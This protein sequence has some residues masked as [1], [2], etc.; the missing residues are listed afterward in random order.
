M[1]TLHSFVAGSGFIITAFDK[2]G[3]LL[4][5]LGDAEVVQGGPNEGTLFGE[6]TGANAAAAP[7]RSAQYC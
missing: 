7:T 2:E 1:K 3:I 6:P 4:E 5:V